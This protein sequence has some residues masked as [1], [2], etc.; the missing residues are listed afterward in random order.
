MG[1]FTLKKMKK[2]T[3]GIRSSKELG[4]AHLDLI[5]IFT[6]ALSYAPIDY[7]IVQTAR[8]F[9]EQLDNFLKGKSKL[10]PRIPEQ[11][12]KAKH[13]ITATRKAA[14]AVDIALYVPEK[15]E[16][17]YHVQGI[18]LVAGH[19]LATANRLYLTGKINHQLRWGGNWDGDNEIVTDQ[20]F[21][22]LVHFELIKP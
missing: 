4:K 20:S 7:S 14:E 16:L 21:D 15:R 19:I 9:Q 6:E 3:L 22:D 13:V 8:A 10:D 12:E 5:I 17:A 18:I 11:L 1:G 2:N